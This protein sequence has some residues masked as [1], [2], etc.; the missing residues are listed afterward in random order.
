MISV[1]ATVV[2]FAPNG[3]NQVIPK[4]GEYAVTNLE[5]PFRFPLDNVPNTSHGL[6]KTGGLIQ[7]VSTLSD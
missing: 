7:S 2:C 6:R 3:D 4:A 5:T 1:A